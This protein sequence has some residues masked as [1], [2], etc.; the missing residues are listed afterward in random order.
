MAVFGTGAA[1]RVRR[2]AGAVALLFIVFLPL[3]FH[4]SL[5]SPLGSQCSC[6]QSARTQLVLPE[7]SPT[8]VLTPQFTVL[9]EPQ[10]AEWNFTAPRNPFVR[11][12]PPSHFA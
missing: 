3:H 5:T 6:L 11:G 1:T 12:P 9:F 2:F 7:D 8:I 10:I 4:L